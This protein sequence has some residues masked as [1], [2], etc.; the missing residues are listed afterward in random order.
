MDWK[1][2]LFQ[3][4]YT[5][6]EKNAVNSVLDSGWLTMGDNIKQFE[7]NFSALIGPN[8]HSVAVSSATAALH[9]ALLAFDIQEDDEVIIPSLTFV[10]DANVVS[11]V[12]GKIVLADCTSL[13]DWSISLKSIESKITKKTKVLMVCHFA[14][15]PCDMKPIKELCA[16]HNI[17]LIEDASHAP[18]ASVDN[19]SCGAW[20]D[21]NC[22]SFFTNK[23]LS[24]GEGGMLTT[25]N[26]IYAER[27]RFLRSHGMSSATLDRHKGRAISYDV[28]IPGLN[29]RMDEIRAALGLVQLKKLQQSNEKRKLLTERYRTNFMSS[30]VVMPYSIDNKKYQSAYHVLPVLLPRNSDRLEIINGMKAGGIQTSIHFPP[31]WDFAAYRDICKPEDMP[32][33]AEICRRELTLPLYPN[34]TFDQVDI[35]CKTLIDMV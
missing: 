12:K 13:D 34:M 14:G 30:P 35:V 8:I 17:K 15:Y 24:V 9:L 6:E 29:Y 4:N 31:F 23:N 32:I 26:P 27:L 22:F 25:V 21:I 1:I 10:A 7:S 3:L 11:M 5:Q 16:K 18:G 28:I 2:Q 33:T 20:G 19:L